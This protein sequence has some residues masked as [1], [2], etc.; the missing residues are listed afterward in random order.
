[1]NMPF[2]RQ[3]LSPRLRVSF[4]L[5]AIAVTFFALPHT[6]REIG[7]ILVAFNAGA[8]VF[9]ALMVV[10]ISGATATEVRRQSRMVPRSRGHV[11]AGAFVACSSS[12]LAVAFVLRAAEQHRSAYRLELVLAAATVFAAWVL[13]QSVFAMYYARSYYQAAGDD[14]DQGGVQFAGGEAPDYWDFVYFSFTIGTCYATSDILITSRLLRRAALLQMF[15]SFVFY[16]FMVGMVI[17]AIGALL[18]E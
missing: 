16:T 7:R 14:S 1:M 3:S 6:M 18:A 12:L 2:V 13:L 9:L 11:L 15:M 5:L 17:N 10:V 4:S 8:A